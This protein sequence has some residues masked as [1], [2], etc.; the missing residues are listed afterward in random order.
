M[1]REDILPGSACRRRSHSTRKSTN[2]R[3][4]GTMP[5]RDT[6]TAYS[7]GIGKVHPGMTG[8]IWPV[9]SAAPYIM[10][11]NA[12]M[13]TPTQHRFANHP[14]IRRHETRLVLELVTRAVRRDQPE[15]V[16]AVAGGDVDGIELRPVRTAGSAARSASTAMARRPASAPCATAAAR[17]WWSSPAARSARATRHRYASSN[18]SITRFV[19]RST[20][21]TSG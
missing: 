18:R 2:A 9:R 13:P 17:R 11:G 16:A 14:E 8:D 19:T 20:T 15:H 5:W 3:M 6:N 10:S 4:A 21:R 7:C 1:Q 12:A